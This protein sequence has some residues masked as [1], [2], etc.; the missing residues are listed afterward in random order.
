MKQSAAS[1]GSTA[2]HAGTAKQGGTRKHAPAAKKPAAKQGAR[3]ST[4]VAKPAAPAKARKLALGSLSCCSAQAVAMS[5][6]LAG[7]VMGADDIEAL[8]WATAA[9][10]DAGASILATLE[11][12][13]VHGLASVGPVSF[14]PLFEVPEQGEPLLG[15]SFHLGRPAGVRDDRDLHVGPVHAFSVILGLE[16]PGPHAVLAVGDTWWSWGR[17]WHRSA[18]PN[19]RVEEAWAV[20]WS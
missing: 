8:Y 17:P 18:F 5:A 4:T 9:S 12:A 13:S 2:K 19:A 1:T 3:K 6:R 16:L 15:G 11:A 14:R 20:S 7:A 10:E